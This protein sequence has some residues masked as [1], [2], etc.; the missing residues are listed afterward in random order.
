MFLKHARFLISEPILCP[1]NRDTLYFTLPYNTEVGYIYRSPY[2]TRTI[3]NKNWTNHSSSIITEGEREMIKSRDKL[4]SKFLNF[5]RKL[6]FAKDTNRAIVETGAKERDTW[7]EYPIILFGTILSIRNLFYL[8]QRCF[9]RLCTIGGISSLSANMF[10]SGIAPT[11][12]RIWPLLYPRIDWA[13][14]E[15][16]GER[17]GLV[18]RREG[19]EWREKASIPSR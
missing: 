4:K 6:K 5:Q 14:K 10:Y 9:C 16:T 8:L 11:W 15:N 7:L 2:I 3:A 13:G 12:R 17:R 19:R 18:R 1:T